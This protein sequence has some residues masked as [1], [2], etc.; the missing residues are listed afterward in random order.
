VFIS[1]VKQLRMFK[2]H[3]PFAKTTKEMQDDVPYAVKKARW[4]TL[5]TLIFRDKHLK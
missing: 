1:R 3:T 5:E 2:K 4:E